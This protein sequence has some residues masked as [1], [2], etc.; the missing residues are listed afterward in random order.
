MANNI[1]DI[2]LYFC[3]NYPCSLCL[4]KARMTKLV[5]LADW[6]SAII[7]DRQITNIEWEFNHFG[8]FVKDV[9]EAVRNDPDIEIEST[10]NFYGHHKEVFAINHE[11]Y[12]NFPPSLDDSTVQILDYVIKHTGDLKWNEFIQLIYST[13]PIISQPRYSMLNLVALAHE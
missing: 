3:L 4:S 5:Y 9:E 10:F 12:L 11:D 7:N 8:P 1:R 6:R 13:Y 2:V